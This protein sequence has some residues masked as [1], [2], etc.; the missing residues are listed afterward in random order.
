M[1]SAM[2]RPNFHEHLADTSREIMTVALLART[3]PIFT[4]PVLSLPATCRPRERMMT[5]NAALPANKSAFNVVARRTRRVLAGS[6]KGTIALCVSMPPTPLLHR[7]CPPPPPRGG[8]QRRRAP[9]PPS[10]AD[11]GATERHRRR[12]PQPIDSHNR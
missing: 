9:S 4:G 6:T 12:R 11:G 8:W 1:R 3:L 10:G 2:S 7:C 5:K